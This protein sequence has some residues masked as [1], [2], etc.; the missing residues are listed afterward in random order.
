MRSALRG[1]VLAWLSVWLLIPAA[2]SAAVFEP[3][4]FASPQIE[5]RYKAMTAELRCLVCQNA[6]IAESNAPL[7]QDLRREVFR[8]LNE[9]KSDAQIVDYMVQR[10]GDFVLFRPPVKSTTIALWVGPFVL[11]VLGLLFLWRL[12]V[13]RRAAA[14]AVAQVPL[15]EDER[16]RLRKLVAE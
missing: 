6:N 12:L 13:R 3:R 11:I 1:V 5:A 2:S 4:E 9:G 7:A 16:E 10:Y 14:A 15:S 8:L